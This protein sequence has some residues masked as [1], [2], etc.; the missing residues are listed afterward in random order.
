MYQITP[1]LVTA[2]HTASVSIIDDLEII[3]EIIDFINNNNKLLLKIR[4]IVERPPR[5]LSLS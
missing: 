4:V 1:K 5:P 3:I 2:G